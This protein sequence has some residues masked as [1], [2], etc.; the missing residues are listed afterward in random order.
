[1]PRNKEY[2]R[3]NVLDAATKVF[4][5]KGF[6]GT[7]VNNLIEATGLGKRS[8]YQEF[9]NKEALFKECLEN[10]ILNVNKEANSILPRKPLGLQ[11]IIDFFQNRINYASTCDCDGCMVVKAALEK[12]LIDVQ[13][14]S[15]VQ[16]ALTGHE[17]AFLNCLVAAQE[18][19]EISAD[20]DCKALAGYLMTFAV[21]MMV[22]GKTDVSRE[23]LEAGVKVLLSVL[24]N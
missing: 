24:T 8:L 3:E 18:N 15:I 20:K 22:K 14:F 6:T 12:E 13:I 5:K 16:D 4:W 17:E 2:K 10:Y 21:G 19:G 1:M 9:G 23:S 11:N 7:S